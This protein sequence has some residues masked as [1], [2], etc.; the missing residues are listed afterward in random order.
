MVAPFRD[1]ANLAGDDLRRR[2]FRPSSP[3]AS[4]AGSA[5]ARLEKPPFA[6]SSWPE[7]QGKPAAERPC[8]G[9]QGSGT[10]VRGPRTPLPW[11]SGAFL[12]LYG[13][14]PRRTEAVAL[15]LADYGRNN[16]AWPFAARETGSAACSRATARNA[17]SIHGAAALRR[18]RRSAPSTRSAA[19]PPV[20]A[21][22]IMVRLKRREAGIASCSPRDLRRTFVSDPLEAGADIVIVQRL[23]GHAS[24][25]ITARYDRRETKPCNGRRPGCAWPI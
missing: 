4:K 18:D 6:P 23:A 7:R 3:N 11:E 12:L 8:A 16:G 17:P 20:T 15:R 19:S 14:G 1:G 9:F 5:N 22:A 25:L 21:Q 10:A 2:A 24:P 13:V